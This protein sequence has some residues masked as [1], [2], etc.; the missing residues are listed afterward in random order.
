MR[1]LIDIP[2]QQIQELA[3]ISAA[4]KVPRAQLVREALDDFIQRHR[5]ARDAAFGIWRGQVAILPGDDQ[6]LPTDGLDYQERLR[7]DW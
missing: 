1:I 6:P 5:P 4:R 7:S 3:A 2:D